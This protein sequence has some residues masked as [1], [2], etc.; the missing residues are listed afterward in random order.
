MRL[1]GWS[2]LAAAGSGA[3]AV[4]PCSGLLRAIGGCVTRFFAVLLIPASPRIGGMPASQQWP[5]A[6]SPDQK[7]VS[8]LDLPN[9]TGLP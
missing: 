3:E 7:R 5:A 9:Y 4:Y 6:D 1:A 8:A 2:G